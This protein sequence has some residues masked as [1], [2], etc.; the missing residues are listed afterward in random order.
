MESINQ[1]LII[2]FNPYHILF[3]Y[4]I[5]QNNTNFEHS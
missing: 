3:G 2:Y 1:I 5:I 4:L